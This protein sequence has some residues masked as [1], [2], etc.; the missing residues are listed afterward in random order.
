MQEVRGKSSNRNPPVGLAGGN[1][2]AKMLEVRGESSN[3][4]PRAGLAG[5]GA[6]A[7]MLEPDAIEPTTSAVRLLRSIFSP[8][9]K[10][11]LPLI[12]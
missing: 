12:I 11:L 8:F 10:N 6:Q 9:R 3:R 4:N 7:K 5:G 2:Q 1:R